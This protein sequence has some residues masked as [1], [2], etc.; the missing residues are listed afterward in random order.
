VASIP[1]LRYWRILVK[2]V[3]DKDFEYQTHG[4]MD[5][6]HRWFFTEKSMHRMFRSAGY[7]VMRST[8]IHPTGSRWF[9]MANLVSLGSLS[10]MA[11]HQFVIVARPAPSESTS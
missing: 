4:I 6:T 3:R 11:F 2:L 9:K 1:N 7:E 8:G 5:E 10:D